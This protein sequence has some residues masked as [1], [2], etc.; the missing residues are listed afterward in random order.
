[1]F[2]TCLS[3]AGSLDDSPSLVIAYNLQVYSDY[4]YFFVVV[5]AALN[6]EI[7]WSVSKEVALA[8]SLY[9]SN[10]MTMGLEEISW[11]RTNLGG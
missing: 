2:S 3:V 6:K 8:L 10:Q 9:C 7:M 4:I 1:M 5:V 11:S